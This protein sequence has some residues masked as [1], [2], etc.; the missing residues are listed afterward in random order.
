MA[1]DGA[2]VGGA[3]GGI[4]FIIVIIILVCCKIACWAGIAYSIYLCIKGNQN[5]RT[6]VMSQHQMAYQSRTGMGEEFMQRLTFVKLI[7]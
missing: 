3:L 2:V 6:A 7:A 5:Q 4:W 1:S